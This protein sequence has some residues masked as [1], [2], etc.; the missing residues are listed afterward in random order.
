MRKIY[1]NAEISLRTLSGIYTIAIVLFLA[2]ASAALADTPQ[3]LVA[4]L[5]QEK[6]KADEMIACEAALKESPAAKVLPLLLPL[7]SQGMPSGPI[8]NSGGAEYDIEAKLNW[9]VFYFSSRVWDHL[10]DQNPKLAGKLLTDALAETESGRERVALLG[11]LQKTWNEEAEPLAAEILRSWKKE[12][13]AWMAAAY[14]LAY[15]HR[16][17]YDELFSRVLT[18]LPDETWRQSNTKANYIRLLIGHRNKALFAKKKIGDT[19]VP[20]MNHEILNV[21]FSLIDKMEKHR[22]GFGYY[23]ALGM[24]DYVEQDFKP[25]QKDPRFKKGE[26]GLSEAFFAETSINALRWWEKNNQLFHKS[27]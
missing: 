8:W 5:Q 1:W 11:L 19:A 6:L 7:V 15:H 20:L 16:E 2:T 12:S 10:A 24:A 9:R 3:Q 26:G 18:E 22:D 14:C 27:K 25:D 21:G 17:K 23:L 4:S 13:D